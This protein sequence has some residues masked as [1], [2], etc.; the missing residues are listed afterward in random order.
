MYGNQ[1]AVDQS[2]KEI[3]PVLVPPTRET[4]PDEPTAHNQTPPL[5]P[6]QIS[7]KSGLFFYKVILSKLT[8]YDPRRW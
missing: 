6:P 4:V 1:T 8:S 3:T 5:T 7:I 2:P